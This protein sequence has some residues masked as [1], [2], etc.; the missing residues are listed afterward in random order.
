MQEQAAPT[1]SYT[2]GCG[3]LDKGRGNRESPEIEVLKEGV[4]KDSL[5]EKQVNPGQRGGRG[6]SSGARAQGSALFPGH[7]TGRHIPNTL[8]SSTYTPL[9]PSLSLSRRPEQKPRASLAP[10]HTPLPAQAQRDSPLLHS[11]W[12]KHP[13]SP[14]DHWSHCVVEGGWDREVVGRPF[15]WCFCEGPKA[16]LQE[17]RDV[18]ASSSLRAAGPAP[19]PP[20]LPARAPWA[21]RE[22]ARPHQ[23]DRNSLCPGTSSKEN[24][25]TGRSW[26]SLSTQQRAASRKREEG[27]LQLEAGRPGSRG[28]PAPCKASNTFAQAKST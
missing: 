10:A 11:P 8:A 15:R 22:T 4:K 27:S 6:L 18:S 23:A 2:R 14:L 5:F 3:C 20:G 19:H 12:L 13:S 1:A 28:V 9:P 24:Q 26:T 17:D 7:P 21:G 25:R 16:R